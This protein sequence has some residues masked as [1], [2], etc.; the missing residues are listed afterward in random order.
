MNYWEISTSIFNELMRNI[1][2][3]KHAGSIDIIV[4]QEV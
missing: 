4:P 1:D 2:I 3:E